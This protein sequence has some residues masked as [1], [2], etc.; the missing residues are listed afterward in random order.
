MDLS[1]DWV[2]RGHLS[3]LDRAATAPLLDGFEAEDED[4]ET[5]A[6][7]HATEVTGW[8]WDFRTA[9]S[10][11]AAAWQAIHDARL[12]ALKAGAR[13]RRILA[14]AVCIRTSPQAITA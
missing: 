3:D 9:L 8:T 4:F 13:E 2:N 1:E 7:A 5:Q 10:D 6:S 11:D 14:L 12:S